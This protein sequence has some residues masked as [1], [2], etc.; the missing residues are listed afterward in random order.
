MELDPEFQKKAYIG[1][2]STR[3]K[4]PNEVYMARISRLSQCR[5]IIQK[6]IWTKTNCYSKLMWTLSDFNSDFLV[7]PKKNDITIEE[8][9]KQKWK[10]QMAIEAM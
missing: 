8:N 10:L 4:E 6:A 5:K 3:D 1:Y 9:L 7:L 2:W